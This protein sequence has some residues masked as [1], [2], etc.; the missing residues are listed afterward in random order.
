M[1]GS[2]PF[3]RVVLIPANE[4]SSRDFFVLCLAD[5]DYSEENMALEPDTFDYS[6]GAFSA[7]E[8]SADT[9]DY[10]ADLMRRESGI[11]C[12][13]WSFMHKKPEQIMF[14]GLVVIRKP[15]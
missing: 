13:V 14:Q 7:M 15:E 10:I 11:D 12:K 2:P 1:R 5:L 6:N 3:P 4:Q 8:L 9:F